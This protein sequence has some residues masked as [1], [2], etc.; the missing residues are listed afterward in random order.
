MK[1]CILIA[2]FCL[3]SSAYAHA[4]T[5]WDPTNWIENNISA[6]EAV[7]QSLRQIEQLRTQLEN[8]RIDLINMKNPD[9][10]SWGDLQKVWADMEQTM[11]SLNKLGGMAS[12]VDEYLGRMGTYKSYGDGRLH[13]SDQVLYGEAMGYQVY[14]DSADDIMRLSE[15]Q[16]AILEALSKRMDE[17]KESAASA[18][19]QQAA[20]QATNQIL[21]VMSEQLANVH[22]LL[23]AQNTLLGAKSEREQNMEAMQ[24]MGE[25]IVTGQTERTKTELSDKNMS[26]SVSDF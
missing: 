12:S 7:K 10:F 17:I 13:E 5:V 26:F 3:F 20:I 11:T 8:L 21:T 6:V 1:K 14:K 19:G 9:L 16:I 15:R 22:A 2:C 24:K 23:T 25:A 4:L 18:E